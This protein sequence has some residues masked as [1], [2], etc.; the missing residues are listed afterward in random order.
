[1]AYRLGDP[2]HAAIRC[3]KT[4]CNR[5]LINDGPCGCTWQDPVESTD[6]LVGQA[7]TAV[8]ADGRIIASGIITAADRTSDDLELT[9]DQYPT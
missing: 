7:V 9:V 3:P 2:I 4:D 6:P 1:M 5:L 8:G